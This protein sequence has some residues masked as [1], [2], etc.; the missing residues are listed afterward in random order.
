MVV[1]ALRSRVRGATFAPGDPP[2]DERRRVWNARVDR[3]PAAVV[4]PVD[5]D[6]VRAAVD[7]A[8][9]HDRPVTPRAGGHHVSGAA[10]R[11]GAVVLDLADL[12]DVAVDPDAR[13]A[14]V[15]GGAT[16]GAVDR[17]TLEHGLAAPGAQDPD[18]GVAGSTLGGG[19]GWRSRLDGLSCDNLRAADVVVADGSLVRASADEHPDLYWA[20]RGGGGHFGVVTRFVFDLHPASTTVLAGSVVHRLEDAGAAARAYRAFVEDA[21]REAR[22]LLGVMALPP[23]S[24]YPERL[25]GRRVAMLVVCHVGDPDAAER[26]LAGLRSAGDPLADSVH[27]RPY[28]DW[29]RAGRSGSSERT[30]VRSDLVA[31]L[32]DEV[33]EVVVR[34]GAAA[35]S[36]S[37]T[38][39]VSPRGGAEVDPAPDETAYP[40]R[41]PGHHVLVEA[42]WSDPD[43]DD[44]HLAWV[45]A[46]HEALAPHATG[47]AAPN[48]LDAA[49]GPG[50]VRATY[51]DHLDRLVAV[52]DRWDPEHRFPGPGH[53]TPSG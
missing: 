2:Y 44:E 11:D 37:S 26:D 9:R 4:R 36:P 31:D 1:D 52:K 50:R 48:F 20:L 24:V 15:G 42:R 32:T 12:D 43:R 30:A 46:A 10:V 51:G 13:T 8:R 22:P 23:A 7:V 38:V 45:E 28:V 34:H 33:V 21:P 53:V 40:H 5:A 29:Q 18:V 49:E 16:W 25:H 3:R 14:R 39:F 6:D 27:R 35:P 41:E 19:V 47:G 17:A